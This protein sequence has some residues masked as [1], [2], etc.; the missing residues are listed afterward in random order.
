MSINLD[1]VLKNRYGKSWKGTINIKVPSY[2][3]KQI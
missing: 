2:W 1:V 3:N